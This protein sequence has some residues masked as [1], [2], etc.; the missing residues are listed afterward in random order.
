MLGARVNRVAI[1][2]GD[3]HRSRLSRDPARRS[4]SAVDSF[5]VVAKRGFFY[6]LRTGIAISILRSLV[7]FL[8]S[9]SF[10][11][12]VAG[13]ASVGT[14]TKVENQAQINGATASVG[15]PVQPN[16]QLRTGTKSR[17][18]VTF[19]DNTKFTLGENASAVVDRFV[20]NPDQSTGELALRT[21]AAAF[22]MATGK[23]SAMGDKKINVVTPFAALAVR[24]TDFWWGPIEG[25]FGALLV[26]NSRVDV[27][28]EE[29]EREGM[30][31]GE[32][33]RCRCA[34]TL[35]EA[36]EGTDIRRGCPGP[37]SHW[38]PGKVASALASTTFGLALAPGGLAPAAIGA[39]AV[40]AAFAAE[41]AND[42]S[43]KQSDFTNPG[44]GLNP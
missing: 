19:R 24:G 16:D 38:P 12:H 32:R 5:G 15:T 9:L 13:A 2:G 22:R 10:T 30:D 26:S 6:G 27:R 33:E 4:F 36:G 35:D 34:V 11:T 40:G 29:C 1:A 23:L 41:T 44:E 42:A 8:L 14:I 17:L 31:D 39:A 25:Q 43:P 28:G 18:E 20:F 3:C 21:S 37:P 7:I